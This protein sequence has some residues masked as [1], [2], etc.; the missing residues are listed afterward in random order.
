MHFIVSIFGHIPNL[1]SSAE[2]TITHNQNWQNWES[3]LTYESDVLQLK[4]D[5]SLLLL[6]DLIP[7]LLDKHL[8]Q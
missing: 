4:V 1:V 7:K 5:P 8:Y 2:N 3:V 6:V